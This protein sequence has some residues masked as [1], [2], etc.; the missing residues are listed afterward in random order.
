MDGNP[1]LKQGS[2]PETKKTATPLQPQ[3]GVAFGPPIK[4][5]AEETTPTTPISAEEVDR[6]LNHAGVSHDDETPSWL[7]EKKARLAATPPPPVTPK[8]KPV[9]LKVTEE[10]ANSATLKNIKTTPYGNIV[11][12]L[13]TYKDDIARAISNKNVSK[14]DIAVAQQERN[15]KALE[16]ERAQQELKEEIE[17]QNEKLAAEKAR[18]KLPSRINPNEEPESERHPETVRAQ[19]SPAAR[20]NPPPRPSPAP[21]PIVITEEDSYKKGELVAEATNVRER[22]Q[23]HHQRP[24][25][26]NV[27]VTRTPQKIAPSATEQ[28]LKSAQA[29]LAQRAERVRETT[30]VHFKEKTRAPRAMKIALACFGLVVIG[31]GLLGVTLYLNR[32]NPG[33][34]GPLQIDTLVFAEATYPIAVETVRGRAFMGLLSARG[35]ELE[36][37]LNA[38]ASLELTVP[39]ALGEPETI[40]TQEWFK[41]AETGA[42]PAL[43]RALH[44]AF[45]LG[46]HAFEKNQPFLV[47]KTSFY[48]NAFAGMLEWETSMSR[49]L[50]PLFGN[51]LTVAATSSGVSDSPFKDR[52]IQNKDT[53]VLVDLNGEIRLIYSF[54]DRQTLV[55]TTNRDTLLELVSRLSSTKVSR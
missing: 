27:A 30:P 38:V 49:D 17:R 41:K 55:I 23:Q 45:M 13:R 8:P 22:E 15:L 25:T 35:I 51:A 2:T 10:G 53:R 54:I 5:P 46:I 1:F 31:T 44:P 28:K 40:T 7:T 52:L 43:I 20:V 3:G 9:E 14:T 18:A 12:P 29:E 33:S 47:F 36:L 50:A 26:P 39:S 37:P 4:D 32:D 34:L 24:P 48:E 42:P 6:V 21:K 16:E 11:R 19:A